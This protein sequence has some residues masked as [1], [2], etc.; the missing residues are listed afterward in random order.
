M[1]AIPLH[2]KK[3]LSEKRLWTPEILS[4]YSN[5]IH[6]S[7]KGLLT[8]LPKYLSGLARVTWTEPEFKQGPLFVFMEKN[9]QTKW[10]HRQ[11]SSEWESREGFMR[12]EGYGETYIASWNDT[13]ASCTHHCG[14][15]HGAPPVPF[16]ASLMIYHRKQ[17]LLKV[18]RDGAIGCR[19]EQ[20][21]EW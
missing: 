15:N 19:V 12:K 13:I 20:T 16:G 3:F 17:G 9:V 14:L 10:N 21:G 4:D 6:S 18:V 5:L 7:C 1:T 2:C 8:Q 11:P